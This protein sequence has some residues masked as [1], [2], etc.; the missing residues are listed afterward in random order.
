MNEQDRGLE[1]KVGI[2]VAAGLAILA[3]LVVEFGRLGE[4]FQT[5]YPLTVHFE[6]ASGLLKSSDVLLGGAKVGRVAGPPRLVA[7]G[8]GV[9]VPLKI[10]D[11]VKIPAGSTFTVGSSG[12]LGDRFVAVFPPPGKPEK[13]IA[14]GAHIE[15]K[16]EEGISDMTKQGS[17]LL[18]ELRG[19]V[20]K[21]D[22]A[23]SHLDDQALSKENM[24]HLHQTFENL[25][26]TT[27]ALAESSGKI[28]GVVEKADAAMGSAKEAADKIDR[29]AA[30]ARE[31]LESAQRLLK[32]ARS[33]GGVVGMLLTN[34]AVANDLRALVSNLRRHGVLFYRDSAAKMSPPPEN[35]PA[36]RRRGP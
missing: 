5:Y 31:A 4:G 27:A 6:D 2:F 7:A 15:G 18:K 19:T 32:E 36:P 34:E 10:Y 28:D 12:L 21:I 20:A 24:K 35:T 30:D 3:A 29:A 14:K 25:D 8:R 17:A 33:G 22:S 9:N 1:L 26:K 11:Y 13:F 16:R 23:V